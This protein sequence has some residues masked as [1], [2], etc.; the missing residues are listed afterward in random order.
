LIP[1]ESPLP[2]AAELARLAR[3]PERLEAARRQ[4]RAY[5]G[6]EAAVREQL[7]QQEVEANAKKALK[8]LRS[9]GITVVDW[10]SS[11]SWHA[12]QA[13][14]LTYL[15]GVDQDAHASEPCHAASLSPAGEVVAICTDPA[16]HP[17]P[18]PAWSPPEISEEQQAQREAER[19]HREALNTASEARRTFLCKLL[20]QRIAK[21]QVLEH[22]ALVFVGAGGGMAWEDYELAWGLLDAGGQELNDGGDAQEALVSYAARGPDEAARAGLALAFSISEGFVDAWSADWTRARVHLE[23][24]QRHGYV[25]SEV[26]RQ[27]LDRATAGE[28]ADAKAGE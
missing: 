1:V 14:P 20:T 13:G 17:R 5:G 22:V 4:A 23:F 3:Y 10:P 8:E 26:E 16:R 6:I 7:R 15:H 11:A 24:L 19:M 2:D 27:E 28:D 9:K 12:Q 18:E 21:G 25:A